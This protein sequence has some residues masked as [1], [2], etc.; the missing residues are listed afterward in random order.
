MKNLLTTDYLNQVLNDR[1]TPTYLEI[2]DE[3]YQHVGHQGVL[4]QTQQAL[5]PITHLRLIMVSEKFQGLSRVSR[6]RLVYEI[7]ENHFEIGLHAV[8]L[9]LMTPTEYTQSE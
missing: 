4:E 3:S 5:H 2:K 8:V 1:F 7:L 6:H 9:N